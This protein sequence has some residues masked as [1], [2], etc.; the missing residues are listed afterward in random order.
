MPPVTACPGSQA[1]Q[2]LLRGQTSDGDAVR[3]EKHVADCPSCFQQLAALAGEKEIVQAMHDNLTVPQPRNPV[4]GRLLYK[5]GRQKVAPL[6]PSLVNT[7]EV[8]L[9]NAGA[10][11]PDDADESSHF[12]GPPQGP[13]EL[14]RL[15]GYRVLRVLG[16]GGMGTVYEAEDVTLRRRVAL[17]TMKP[18]VAAQPGARAR[19]LREARAAA[20]LNHDH[21]VPIYQVGEERSLPFLAMPLLHG[22]ML[23]D[24]LKREGACRWPKRS[25]SAA[26]SPRAWPPLTTTASSTATSSRETSGWRGPATASRS[27][28]SAWPRGR[29]ATCN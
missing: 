3:L 7:G 15:G 22:E 24:R 5:I 13:G 28:I 14:G 27:S 6:P 12:L 16:V 8:S 23:E 4:L 25:A 19:F 1:L 2:Q 17:K 20:A 26:R 10:P 21:V 29:K 18:A 9:T 11:A